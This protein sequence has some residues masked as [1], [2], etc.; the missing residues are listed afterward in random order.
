M[1]S[2]IKQDTQTVAKN[3]PQRLGQSHRSLVHFLQEFHPLEQACELPINPEPATPT[4]SHNNQ[5]SSLGLPFSRSHSIRW[6][7]RP[8]GR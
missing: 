6:M 1:K 7:V 2:K 5:E 4:Q 8:C 3:S